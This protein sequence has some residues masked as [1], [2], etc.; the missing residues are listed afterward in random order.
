MDDKAASLLRHLSPLPQRSVESA[1]LARKGG[2]LNC[3]SLTF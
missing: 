3:A 2:V 1:A